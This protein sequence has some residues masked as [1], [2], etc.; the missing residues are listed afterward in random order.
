MKKKGE[1]DRGME[2][3]LQYIQAHKEEM[4]NMLV[5]IN[6]LM[7][8]EVNEHNLNNEESQRIDSNLAVLQDIVYKA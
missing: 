6:R 1:K 7:I 3:N 8:K 2:I 5:T 4:L